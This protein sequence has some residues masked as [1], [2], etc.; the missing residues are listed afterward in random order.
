LDITISLYL[1]EN[2]PA[3]KADRAQVEQVLT[4]LVNNAADA[5]ADRPLPR[6]IAVTTAVTTSFLR[7][8]VQD[9]GPGVLKNIA[10]RIFDPFFTTK[11]VGRGT[12][13]GLT[14]CNTY[15]QEHHGKIWVESE[16]GKG[17]TF[18]VDL[19]LV[20]CEM[21][22]AAA[23]ASPEAALELAGTTSRRVLIIDDEPD[24]LSVLDA[25]L[26][27]AGYVT[28]TA[29]NGNEA[30]KIVNGEKFDVIL[31]DIRMPGLDGQALYDRIYK[32]SPEQAK[33]VIFV[34]G[35]TVSSQTR[36]FL[37]ATGNQWISKPF[38]ITDVMDRVQEVL[39][40]GAVAA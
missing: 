34:T 28:T 19:P 25:V 22:H 31:S 13:L 23:S 1:D 4:N 33:K 27:D 26:T 29:S 17:A 18:F 10:E 36:T 37:D 15:I 14:I 9:N 39:G 40:A 6:H 3:T 21:P 32:S 38:R 2:L 20:E 7:I 35:D 8:A 16:T 11:P 24:I 12:G 5:V 30:L